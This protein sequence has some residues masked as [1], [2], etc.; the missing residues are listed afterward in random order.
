MRAFLG[1]K[2]KSP[3]NANITQVHG[4]VEITFVKKKKNTSD[5]IRRVFVLFLASVTRRYFLR[6]LRGFVKFFPQ[7]SFKRS[8]NDVFAVCRYR[9]RNV[10]LVFIWTGD[11]ATKNQHIIITLSGYLLLTIRNSLNSCGTLNTGGHGSDGPNSGT[12]SSEYTTN[13]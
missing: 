7:S 2:F 6:G 11:R 4:N 9:G 8:P 13:L 3:N 5:A 1:N 12:D 10:K